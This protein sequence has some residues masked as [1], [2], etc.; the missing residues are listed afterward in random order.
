MTYFCASAPIFINL[1]ETKYFTEKKLFKDLIYDLK[2]MYKE[3]R[4]TRSIIYL[5]S[6]KSEKLFFFCGSGPIFI[7]LTETKYLKKNFFNDLKYD[8]KIPYK[9]LRST[10]SKKYQI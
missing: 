9:E 1:A 7:N 5:K 2:K 3:L 10:G 4:S 8:L 6:I